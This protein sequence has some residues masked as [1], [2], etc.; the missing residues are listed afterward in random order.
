MLKPAVKQGMNTFITPKLDLAATLALVADVSKRF[1]FQQTF[2]DVT[3]LAEPEFTCC[4][5]S[6]I[7]GECEKH[8]FRF[9]DRKSGRHCQIVL[10]TVDG[11]NGI[12]YEVYIYDG[13]KRDFCAWTIDYVAFLYIRALIKDVDANVY[14]MWIGR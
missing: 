13:K 1:C 6:F 12:S 5:V 4:T 7:N 3:S 9:T 2:T 10:S 14:T 11:L 8:D